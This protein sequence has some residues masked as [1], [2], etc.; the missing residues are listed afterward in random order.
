VLQEYAKHYGAGE[1]WLFLTGPKLAVQSLENEGLKL[2]M[3]E[4]AAAKERVIHGTKF[5]LVD[6]EANVRAIYDGTTGDLQRI[7]ADVHRLEAE[8]AE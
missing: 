6:R 7:A 1:H 3:A 8:P 2:G 5:V 4:D